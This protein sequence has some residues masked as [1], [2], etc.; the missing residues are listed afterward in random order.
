M[1]PTYYLLMF[2]LLLAASCASPKYTYHFDH[3]N[4]G[5]T[6]TTHEGK[7]EIINTPAS[8]TLQGQELASKSSLL[9]RQPASQRTMDVEKGEMPA[10]RLTVSKAER[11]ELKQQIKKYIRES[12][13]EK[14]EAVQANNIDHDLKLAAVFGSVGVVALIIG[15]DAFVIIGGIALIIGVV[16]FVRWLLRQ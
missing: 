11:R 10:Q 15:T 12:K 4:Y 13:N 14:V 1:K 3:Y 16:F 7:T 5:V 8:G 6:K 2:A 9:T